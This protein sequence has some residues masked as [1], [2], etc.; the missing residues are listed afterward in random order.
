M[1]MPKI[2]IIED[3]EM[4]LD[5]LVQLLEEDYALVTAGDGVAGLEAARRERPDA[6]LMDLSLPLMD[7]WELA[8]RLKDDPALAAIPLVALTAHAMRGDEE[9]ALAAGCDGYLAKPVDEDALFALLARV[10]GIAA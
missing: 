1:T 5:L 9:R 6:I 7:G 8:R 2:L 3:V 10:T 4:N